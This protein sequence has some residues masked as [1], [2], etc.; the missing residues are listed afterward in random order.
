[1]PS[2]LGQ[3]YRPHFISCISKWVFILL[4]HLLCFLAIALSRMGR[5]SPNSTVVFDIVS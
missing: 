3:N 2:D 4:S 5:F 1:M